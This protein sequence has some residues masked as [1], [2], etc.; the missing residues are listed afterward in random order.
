MDGK[1]YYE[2]PIP[3]KAGVGSYT[4]IRFNIFKVKKHYLK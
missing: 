4:D 2:A 1:R 3:K